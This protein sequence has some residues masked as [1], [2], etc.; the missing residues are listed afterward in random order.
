M[1][2]DPPEGKKE[3]IVAAKCSSIERMQSETVS[4]PFTIDKPSHTQLNA[5]FS[6]WHRTFLAIA[7]QCPI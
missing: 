3:K 6:Q 1:S 5:T 7:A 4:K 2:Y